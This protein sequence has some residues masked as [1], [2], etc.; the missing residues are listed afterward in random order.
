M[1]S[2]G[3]APHPAAVRG[4]LGDIVEKTR[5]ANV[6]PPAVILVGGVAALELISQNKEETQ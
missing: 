3:N 5:A 6:Q 2:G 4:T 1:V